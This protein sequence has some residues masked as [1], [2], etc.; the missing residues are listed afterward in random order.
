MVN[1]LN[2]SSLLLTTVARRGDHNSMLRNLHSWGWVERFEREDAISAVAVTL[3]R[4]ELSHA[5][6]LDCLDSHGPLSLSD[7]CWIC[8][9]HLCTDTSSADFDYSLSRRKGT[10]E[11]E[12]GSNGKC[13]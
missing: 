1:D 10:P 7:T 4:T 11:A 5:V 13:I 6:T 8:G 3:V 9:T 12:S 2:T